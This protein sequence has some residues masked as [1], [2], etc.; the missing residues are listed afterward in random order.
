MS[1]KAEASG[2]GREALQAENAQLRAQ[3]AEMEGYLVKQALS[4]DPSD[5][6]AALEQVLDH[7]LLP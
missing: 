6:L 7:F 4:L 1:S 5:S 2:S 3:V